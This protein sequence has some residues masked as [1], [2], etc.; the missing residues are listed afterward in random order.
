MR[1]AITFTLGPSWV[2]DFGLEGQKR[3]EFH[4]NLGS[5]DSGCLS[6]SQRFWVVGI[7]HL[8]GER[9]FTGGGVA[10]WTHPVTRTP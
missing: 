1:Q 10:F 2:L 5:S 3:G 6:K 8:V 9:H 4:G 7:L